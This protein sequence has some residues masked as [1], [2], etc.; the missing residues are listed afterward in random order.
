MQRADRL[1]ALDFVAHLHFHLVDDA[2]AE[3]GNVGLF[4]PVDGGVADGER[5]AG[6]RAWL[7]A[8]ARVLGQGRGRERSDKPRGHRDGFRGLG[9][10]ERSLQGG[11]FVRLSSRRGAGRGVVCW[12]IGRGSAYWRNGQRN[13]TVSYHTW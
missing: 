2:F 11:R 6:G 5:L 3:G 7:G 10:H 1:A 4:E 9:D 13:S 8:G 12:R